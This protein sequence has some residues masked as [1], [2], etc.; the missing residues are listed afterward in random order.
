M[1][2]IF[3]NQGFRNVIEIIFL[4][5]DFD[6]LLNCE[7]INKHCR[8]ILKSQVFW[9]N[10]WTLRGISN[11][12]KNDWRNAIKLTR[13]RNV[14]G[15]WMNLAKYFKR[16][17]KNTDLIDVPCYINKMVFDQIAIWD[18]DDHFHTIMEIGFIQAKAIMM[19]KFNPKTTVD[20]TR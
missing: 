12:N 7:L 10:K 4:Y 3:N 8:K 19:E 5:L 2:E 1:E 15:L 14:S 20:K 18:L 6:D 11:K 13:R 16:I 9:F 17:V